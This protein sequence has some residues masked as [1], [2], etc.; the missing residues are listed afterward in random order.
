MSELEQT[1]RSQ[2]TKY[3]LVTGAGARVGRAIALEL[4]RHGFYVLVHYHQN[5]AGAQ[6]T[7]EQVKAL[8]GDG[9]IISANLGDEADRQA[10]IS[11]TQQACP[12]LDLL[13]NNASLFEPKAFA[14]L[15][16][17]EWQMMFEVNL[18]A[19]YVLAQGLLAQL[20]LGQGLIVNLC[21][22]GAERPLKGYA[23][24]SSSKAGLVGLTRSL[25]VELA[26]QVRCVG[27]SP[28]QVAWPPDFSESQK[29][30][31]IQRIP[32]ARSGGPEDI[33]HLLRF[34]WQ[35]GHYLNGAIIP[36]DGG[37]SCRY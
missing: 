17:A 12:T 5:Q 7:L 37:L 11:A 21:D 13:V 2:D 35:E 29:S 34:I 8:G 23:H 16:L 10:L 36:V 6:T 22:I 4:A 27:L 26:P 3:A 32:M 15:P 18:V 31:I 33:A 9:Q 1:D 30:K 28:G 20:T 25:A 19:P 14:E 24:Y